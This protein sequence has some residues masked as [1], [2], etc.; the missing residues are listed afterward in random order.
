M[1]APMVRRL[2][3]AGYSVT[4]W[5]R[6]AEK[7]RALVEA[8]AR[9][10]LTPAEAVTDADITFTM[11]SDGAAVA[12]VLFARGAAQALREGSVLIDTSSISPDMARDHAARLNAL[13]ITQIDC[14]VSGGTAGAEAGTLAL[15]AGGPAET[16]TRIAPVF[17]PLGRLTHVG[18]AGAGQ[19]CKLANQ[20]IVAITIGAVAEAM[21][22]VKAGGADPAKFRD[23]IRGGFAESRILELHGARMIERDFTPGGPSRLHLKDLNGVAALAE[24]NQLELPLTETVRTAYE[25]FVA[26]GNGDVDHSGL[27]LFLE[28]LNGASTREDQT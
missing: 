8:G 18:P 13:G 23:A 6:A 16:I 14:P 12:D 15:M 24:A 10:A 5:N 17:E 20:Q 2:L 25:T 28:T 3:G 7:A 4:V 27:L 9:Q 21:I 19:V 11:L 1:G 26:A 22:L